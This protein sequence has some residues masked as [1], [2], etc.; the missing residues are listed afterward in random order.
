[1]FIELNAVSRMDIF[2][3]CSLEVENLKCD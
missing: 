2:G 3:V 1:M